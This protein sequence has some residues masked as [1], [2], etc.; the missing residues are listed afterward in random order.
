MSNQPLRLKAQDLLTAP[1]PKPQGPASRARSLASIRSSHG[2][3]VGKS[4]TGSL[5][6]GVLIEGMQGSY[7][8]YIRGL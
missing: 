2:S 7:K 1:R 4:I 3:I 5:G 8:D 6:P